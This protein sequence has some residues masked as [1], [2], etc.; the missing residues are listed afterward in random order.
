MALRESA[1]GANTPWGNALALPIEG[2]A[3]PLECR[4][5]FS[6]RCA[7]RRLTSRF[8]PRRGFGLTSGLDGAAAVGP[9]A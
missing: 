9:S 5:S 2:V 6:E 4:A 7:F 3:S 1:Y 8:Q